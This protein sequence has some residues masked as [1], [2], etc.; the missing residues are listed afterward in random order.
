MIE[1]RRWGG[2]VG[3]DTPTGPPPEPP[4][5]LDLT[6]CLAPVTCPLRH[7]REGAPL[8][9]PDQR[10]SPRH[11]VRPSAPCPVGSADTPRGPRRP[12]AESALPMVR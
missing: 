1:L 8:P 7:V 11:S 6:P 2:R 4:A 9:F 10:G 3:P 12:L 5:D